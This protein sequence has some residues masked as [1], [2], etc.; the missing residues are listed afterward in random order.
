MGCLTHGSM[1]QVHLLPA[2]FLPICA[3]VS[4]FHDLLRSFVPNEEG[5]PFL[6]MG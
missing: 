3:Y 4:S 1:I 5:E 2:H 6:G